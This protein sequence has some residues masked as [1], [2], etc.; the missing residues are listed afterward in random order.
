MR[1]K[2]SA[3]VSCRVTRSRPAKS[4]GQSRRFLSAWIAVAVVPLQEPLW[5]VLALLSWRH[6]KG[7]PSS[8]PPCVLPVAKHVCGYCM[9]IQTPASKV[10]PCAAASSQHFHEERPWHFE[11][12]AV[13]GA[14]LQSIPPWDLERTQALSRTKPTPSNKNVVTRRF[15][16]PDAPFSG[17]RARG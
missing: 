3:R 6:S 2:N 15:H 12:P 13:G 11:L 9:K 7:V 17:S 1:F 4:A 10:I 8:N 5:R 14:V 16:F